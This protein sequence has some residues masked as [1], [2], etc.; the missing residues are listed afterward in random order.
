MRAWRW[1]AAASL[2][3]GMLAGCEGVVSGTEVARVPLQAAA[4]GA[5]GA[6]APVAFTLSPEMNPVAFN[7]RAD[8]SQNPADFGKWN[9]YRAMLRKDGAVVAA[10]TFNINHPVTSRAETSAPPPTQTVHTLFIVDVPG[11]GDYELAITP[12]APVAITLNNA[13]VDARR[14]VRRPPQ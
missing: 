6:Y 10:R 3:A 4:D 9:T 14:N 5:A 13:Q 2:L 11:A 8:F 12:I 7:F 1:I